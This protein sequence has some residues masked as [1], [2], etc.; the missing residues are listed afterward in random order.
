MA[1]RKKE[2]NKRSNEIDRLKEEMAERV[3]KLMKLEYEEALARGESEPQ[4][5][6]FGALEAFS[7]SIEGI[8]SVIEPRM[9][10]GSDDEFREALSEIGTKV[11]EMAI[12][13]AVKGRLESRRIL[14]DMGVRVDPSRKI[15]IR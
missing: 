14:Q 13:G 6:M 7:F 9:A 4:A 15:P 1:S 8:I 12:K 2:T 10:Y 3:V 11:V 5:Y